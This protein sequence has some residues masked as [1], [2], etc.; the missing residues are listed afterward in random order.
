MKRL[1]S[2]LLLL[3]ATSGFA[4]EPTAVKGKIFEVHN[5]DPHDI[6]SAIKLLG[7]RVGDMSVNTEMKTITV[8]DLPENLASI[9]DAIKRLDQPIAA[10]P[11]IEFKI[12]VLIGSKTPLSGGGIP[13]DLEPVVKQLQATLR[14]AHYGLMTSNVQ[15]AKPGAG[16]VT[17]SGIVDSVLLGKTTAPDRPMIYSYRLNRLTA[18]TAAERPAIE[19]GIFQFSMRFPVNIGDKGIQYQNVGFETPVSIRQNEKV[20]IGTTTMGDKALIVVVNATVK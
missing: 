6:V 18:G 20:V 10:A 5:R 1:I 17:G 19:V 15:R 13:E 2:I 11:D 9:E 4:Q 8:R 12:S 7:S 14:Y 16:D 3:V